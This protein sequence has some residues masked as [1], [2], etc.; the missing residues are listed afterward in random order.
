MTNEKNTYPFAPN[1]N[2]DF[3][4]GLLKKLAQYDENGNKVRESVYNY[5]RTGSPLVIGALR[6]EENAGAMA[7]AK[8][9]VFSG[10][11]NLTVQE[12]NTVFD[13]PSLSQANHTTT[14]YTYG[15]SAHKEVTA[16]NQV[17]SDGSI[18]R[19]FFKYIKDY[20]ASP[21]ADPFVQS[22][23]NL[24]QQGIN[25][26]LESYNQLE[27][28]GINRTISASLTGL[29]TWGFSYR[30]SLDLPDSQFSFLN[31]AG[32]SDFQPSSISGGVFSKDSRYI[33]KQQI[34]DYDKNANATTVLMNGINRKAVVT[35]QLNSQPVAVFENAGIGEIA[36]E[37][38]EF[39]YLETNFT[40]SVNPSNNSFVLQPRSG[41]YA[42]NITADNVLS[43]SIT[44]LAGRK[45]Y[46]FSLWMNTSV[47]GNINISLSGTQAVVLP[48]PSTGGQWKYYQ[49]K[50]PVANLQA[51]FTLSF[52]CS[53]AALID[54]IIFYPADATVSSFGYDKD[55]FLKTSA[56][57]T[58][59][60][61]EYYQYDKYLR[62]KNV[63]DQDKNIVLKKTYISKEDQD[64]FKAEIGG[65][66]NPLVNYP[67][68]FID[69]SP[70]TTWNSAGISYTWNFGDG[71]G[72]QSTSQLF[73]EL[74]H[75]YAAAG[76]Y[77]VTF[78]KT[79]QPFGTVSATQTVVVGN[80]TDPVKVY[81]AGSMT[82]T[83]SQNSVIK[84][85]FNAA[86]L[87]TGMST[88]EPGVY[89]LKLAASG[90]YSSSNPSGYKAVGYHAYST[91]N[92]G[93]VEDC[94]ASM[95]TSNQYYFNGLNLTGKYS[96]SFYLDTNA[97]CIPNEIE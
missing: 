15:S 77:V 75:T 90:Q 66:Q 25:I 50:V 68:T 18:A 65:Y 20:G 17:L 39:H 73:G 87:A 59:G 93:L 61:A 43:R 26:P 79:L 91:P 92:T 14:S 97:T 33:N 38:F 74:S 56:T 2:Y 51:N 78:T 82:L 5:A 22:I 45:Y 57:N 10:V 96:I 48:Y 85:V 84:Y 64:N 69:G 53:S 60:I 3:E 83:F 54:D 58:N 31:A 70:G 63:L 41:N 16:K 94:R 6:F 62:L 28:N 46:I 76:S 80:S 29:K 32:V 81:G 12:D 42:F 49:V 88:V 35:D 11:G 72:T 47:S 1:T 7:Y 34:L 23:Y 36:Y 37:N 55:S 13:A 67:Y 52:Q 86:D 44:K 21:S 19:T 71:T 95:P 40:Y 4:R 27:R 24:S 9:T 30:P 8:Y 89:D